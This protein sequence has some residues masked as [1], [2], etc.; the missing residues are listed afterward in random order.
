MI[1]DNNTTQCWEA[2]HRHYF[3]MNSSSDGR[4]QHLHRQSTD[5]FRVIKIAAHGLDTKP[6]R[7]KLQQRQRIPLEEPIIFQPLKFSSKWEIAK[8]HEVV[9]C[10]SRYPA[11][12]SQYHT[13]GKGC[14]L[15]WL[16]D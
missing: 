15:C 3:S 4:P 16:I 9:V 12:N 10:F 13:V 6:N 7:S 8:I 2:N 14:E 11:V 1:W 5:N